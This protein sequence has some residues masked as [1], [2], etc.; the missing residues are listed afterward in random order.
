MGAV[1]RQTEYN[2]S[3]LSEMRRAA[4]FRFVRHAEEPTGIS[5]QKLYFWETGTAF[6]SDESEFLAMAKAYGSTVDSV[7]AACIASFERGINFRRYESVR[8]T[9]Q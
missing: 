2:K 7:K 4:G 6:P 8:S 3:P 1:T 9:L 5:R